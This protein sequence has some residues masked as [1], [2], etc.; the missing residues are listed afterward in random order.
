VQTLLTV[1]QQILCDF[2]SRTSLTPVRLKHPFPERPARML[3]L[4]KL[5]GD[6]FS[7]EHFQRIV[8]LR[9]SLPVYVTVFSTFIRPR[10]TYNLPVLSCE[11]ICMGSGRIFVLD[12]HG[13]GASPDMDPLLLDRLLAVRAAYP[14]LIAHQSAAKDTMQSLRSAAACRLKIPQDLDGQALA[15]VRDYV[16]AYLD[17]ALSAKPLD[18]IALAAAQ[19][20]FQ[21]YLKTVVDHDPGVKGNIMFYGRTGGI[22]RALDMFYGV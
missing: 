1:H 17:H 14:G 6:V 4:I 19:A 12:I 9:I 7:S 21:T 2:K 20:D 13:A 3:G 8:C 16:A 22:E 10:L 15:I 18:D 11:V 5:D